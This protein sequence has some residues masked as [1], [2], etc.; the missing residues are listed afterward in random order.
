MSNHQPVQELIVIFNAWLSEIE[1]CPLV[2]T[3]SWKECPLKKL[4]TAKQIEIIE[5]IEAYDHPDKR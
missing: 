1:K 3:A 2:V 4:I 5:S